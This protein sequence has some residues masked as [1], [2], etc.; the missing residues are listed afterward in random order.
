[1]SQRKAFSF[2]QSNLLVDK[3]NLSSHLSSISRLQ[4]FLFGY[5]LL[6]YPFCLAHLE[7]PTKFI[8]FGFH[9]LSFV[10][11]FIEFTFILKTLFAHFTNFIFNLPFFFYPH[12]KHLLIIII[13]QYHYF[14]FCFIFLIFIFPRSISLIYSI[15]FPSLNLA[16]QFIVKI[17]FH[18]RLTSSFI[19]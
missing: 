2:F 14:I 13:H 16:N 18:F 7:N 4:F 6:T 10:A 8:F 12:S 1:V 19:I 9:L 5:L 11:C 17:S 15:K 3:N